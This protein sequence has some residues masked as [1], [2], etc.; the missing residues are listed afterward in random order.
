[1]P[2]PGGKDQGRLSQSIWRVDIEPLLAKL[3]GES[4]QDV[5]VVGDGGLK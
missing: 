1:M 3:F 5:Y 2:L 4:S